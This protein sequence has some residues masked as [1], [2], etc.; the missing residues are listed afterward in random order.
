MGLV[1]AAAKGEPST[2]ATMTS[3]FASFIRSSLP[4]YRIHM[5]YKTGGTAAP[6]GLRQRHSEHGG[7]ISVQIACNDVRSARCLVRR[8]LRYGDGAKQRAASASASALH[9]SCG[10]AARQ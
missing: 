7:W 8:G 3:A 5:L 2:A 10:A 1:C 6:A 9:R 4:V